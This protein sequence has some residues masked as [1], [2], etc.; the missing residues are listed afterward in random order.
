MMWTCRSHIEMEKRFKVWPYKEGEPPLFHNGPLNNIYSIEGQFIDEFDSGKSP[1]LATHPDE[2][3]AFFLPISIVNIVRF[4]YRPYTTYSRVRLQNIVKDY[5]DLLAS[6]YLYWNRTGGADHFLIAC[7]DWAPDVSAAHPNLYKH[8]MRVLCNADTAIDFQP[9]RDVSLPEIY[10]PFGRLSAPRLGQPPSNRSILAFFAGGDHGGVRKILF[11][12]WKDKD[13]EI[14]V[15]GY[16]PK[17]LNYTEL[18]TQAKFCLCP[19]GYEVA[20]PR[21]VEAIYEGCVPVIISDSYVLP[22]SDVLDWSQFSV[23]VPIAKIPEL[24]MILKGISMEEYL[25]KQNKV[26]QV[27]RHFVLNRPAR[28]F[29]VMHMVM[30]SVW[31]RRLNLRLSL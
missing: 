20:S 7:H 28:P 14:Q 16:L 26:I 1:F 2:A 8:F 13:N 4:V 19:G 11:Q 5:I 29:D 24:K 17:G 21:V 23:H 31:L 12:H 25:E 6:R 10:L 22:F 30:H 27:Q 15:Y 9:T 18:M 3:L